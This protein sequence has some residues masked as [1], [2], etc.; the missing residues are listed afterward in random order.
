[1]GYYNYHAQ[2]KK[3]LDSGKL[4][5]IEKSDNPDFAFYFV[6]LTD[7]GLISK[8]IRPHA[9]SRYIQYLPHL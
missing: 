5:S 6:F 9:T 3:L 1:M 7:K 2:I 8:P 4:V